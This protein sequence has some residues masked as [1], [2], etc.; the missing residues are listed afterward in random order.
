LRVQGEHRVRIAPLT[1]ADIGDSP[2][3]GDLENFGAIALFVERAR[4]VNHEFALNA[5]NAAAVVEICRR[6]DGLPLAIELAAAWARLLPPVALLGLLERRLPLLSGGSSDQPARLRTMRDAVA[7]S[8]DLLPI[9]EQRLFRRLAV[10]TG[11]FALEAAESVAGEQGGTLEL[12][13]ALFDK[14]LLQP[15]PTDESEPRYAMLETVRELALER[16]AQSGEEAAARRA[17]AAHYLEIAEAAARDAGAAGDSRWMRRLT[18]ERP[19]LW[20]ALDWL[21][22]TGDAGAA[23]QMSGSLWHY[24]YRLGELAEG[25]AR[26]E[27]ALAAAPPDTDPAMRARALRGAGVFAWQCGDYEHSRAR[28]E[29]A[30]VAYRGLGDEIGIAWVLNSL[31]CLAATLSDAEE[32]DASMSQALAIFERLD[33][34]VGTVNL[35]SNLGE[36]AEAE[37]QHAVAIARLEAALARWRDL[38]DRVGTVR[39][40]VFLG[41]A[42]LA[43]GEVARAEAVL[44]EALAAI[45]DLDYRQVLPAALRAVAQLAARRGDAAAAARWFGAADR[46][47]E[48]LGMELPAARRGRHERALA[49]VRESLG[50]TAFVTAW[51]AG[52]GLS[53]SQAIT[54]ALAVGGTGSGDSSAQSAS[55]LSRREREV[56][57]LLATGRSDKEIADSLFITRRTASKHVSAI[58]AKLGMH[59]RAAAAAF[60]ARH[61]LA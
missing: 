35:T 32:A 44:M 14:S 38:G 61:G 20:A 7:W 51:A 2:D 26:L 1:L 4:D 21:E 33:D 25:R 12:I 56:L 13:A 36:L 27:L 3:M 45:R 5:G 60:A 31:G 55:R 58:L 15:V 39:T 18:V 49:A 50:E 17:H 23:L 30:L 6:L 57:C 22:Q 41:Q 11:G 54:E 40:Q 43:H 37:G 8:H 52:R 28:L 46:V 19:N 48:T 47:M 24:W 9:E 34:P 53:A 29:A 10:F 16:L 42:L 59:S